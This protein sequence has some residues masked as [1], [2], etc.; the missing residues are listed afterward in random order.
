MMRSLIRNAMVRTTR[1]LAGRYIWTQPNIARTF[2]CRPAYQA[3]FKK[4]WL[5]LM[6]GGEVERRR[7]REA[8]AVAISSANRCFY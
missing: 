7:L 1:R 2:R 5:S 3:S 6:W 8:I 4:A